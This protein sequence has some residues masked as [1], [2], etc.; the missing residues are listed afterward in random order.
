[1]R[2]YLPSHAK[3]GGTAVAALTSQDSHQQSNLKRAKAVLFYS[4]HF[5]FFAVDTCVLRCYKT[6]KDKLFGGE[7]PIELRIAV[8]E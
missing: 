7:S 5:I 4:V 1:L 3:L 2:V 6:Q 8:R